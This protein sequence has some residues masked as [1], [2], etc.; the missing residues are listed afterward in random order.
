MEFVVEAVKQSR[1]NKRE[2]AIDN[3]ELKNLCC[4]E[5]SR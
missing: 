4:D 5:I 3:G 2:T 1:L